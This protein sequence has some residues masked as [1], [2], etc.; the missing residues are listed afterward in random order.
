[1]SVNQVASGFSLANR[2]LLYTS[3]LLSP[4][5]F[6]SGIGNNC[7]S[8]IGFLLYNFY[9]QV[10]WYRSVK[11]KELHALSLMTVNFNFFYAITYLGGISAGN[12]F[13][14]LFLV[15]G[16][17]L[18]M[19]LNTATSWRSWATNQVQGFGEYQ[20]FFFGWRTLGPGWH[21]FLML[22]QIGDIITV[23]V[24]ICVCCYLA[25]VKLI[26][27]K[28]EHLPDYFQKYPSVITGAAVTLLFIWPLILWTEL[29]VQRNHIQSETDWTAVGIFI[30][31][32]AALLAPSSKTFLGCVGWRQ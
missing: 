9:T 24:F 20:F 1:M 26:G 18:V 27:M 32:T 29:I 31:Q 16:T 14:R 15:A 23:L 12:I 11:A 21:L 10:Q 25:F 5:S 6:V 4:A 7:P 8:N 22:W 2:A 19:I 30:F 13:M 28:Q 17:V 3:M